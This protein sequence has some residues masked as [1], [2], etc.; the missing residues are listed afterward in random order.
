MRVHRLEHCLTI[1][2]FS[3]LP[4]SQ[5]EQL[6]K[7]GG[8]GHGAAEL[9]RYAIQLAAAGSR[10]RSFWDT[11]WTENQISIGKLQIFIQHFDFECVVR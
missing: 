11:R 6:L 5:L 10:A 3:I 1:P 7:R 8:F 2:S 9:R 4:Y